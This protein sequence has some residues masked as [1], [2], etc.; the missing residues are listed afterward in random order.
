[1]L[2]IKNVN[3]VVCGC[4]VHNTFSSWY[5]F[6]SLDCGCDPDGRSDA[7]CYSN[8]TCPCLPNVTG[9]KCTEC[10]PL[11]YN[12]GSDTG[13]YSCDCDPVGSTGEDCDVTT[14]QCSCKANVIGRRCD[15]CDAGFYDLGIDGCKGEKL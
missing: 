11:H 15:Q 6:L 4:L 2:I 9:P 7:Q 13:C 12:F 1:M 5:I 3:R 10:A 8:G 14:G